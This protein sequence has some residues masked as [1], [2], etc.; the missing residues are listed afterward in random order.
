MVTWFLFTFPH[1]PSLMEVL[2]RMKFLQY[3]VAQTRRG[4]VFYISWQAQSFVCC[5]ANNKVHIEGLTNSLSRKAQLTGNLACSNLTCRFTG[6]ISFCKIIFDVPDSRD[7]I[8]GPFHHSHLHFPA[9]CLGLD[10]QN[11]QL[12]K[13]YLSHHLILNGQL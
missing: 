8:S 7:E 10:F 5:C 3:F 1:A 6:L 12:Q 11:Y 13:M 2:S 4:N 9:S